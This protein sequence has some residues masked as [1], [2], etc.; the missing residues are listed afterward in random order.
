MGLSEITPFTGERRR[1]FMRALL[2]DVRAFE[3][4]LERGM[5]EE[6][7][8]RIGAEQE[9]FLI[10]GGGHGIAGLAQA[11]MVESA[12]RTVVSEFPATLLSPGPV[13]ESIN[14]TVAGLPGRQAI[15]CTYVGLD[16]V[17]RKL[18]YVNAGGAPP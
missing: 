10:D 18:A 11:Q 17:S 9:A 3:F 14:R 1:E 6:G 13:L 8:S 5:F 16:L 12:I 2:A 4:M 7:V 15:A